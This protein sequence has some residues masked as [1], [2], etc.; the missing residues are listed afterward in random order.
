MSK[1]HDKLLQLGVEPAN[2]GSWL[3]RAVQQAALGMEGRSLPPRWVMETSIYT[4]VAC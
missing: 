2:K 3:S 1:E 4:N